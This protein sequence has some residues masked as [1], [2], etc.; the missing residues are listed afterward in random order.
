VV[1]SLHRKL[2]RD[3]LRLKGQA[4]TIALVLL[5]GVASWVSLR[6]TYDSL[7]DARVAY[8]ERQRFAD[9]FASCVRAPAAL[10]SRLAEIAGVKA[11]S[12]SVVEPIRIMIPSR[13]IPPT[14]VLAS[15][16][17]DPA[18]DAPRLMQGRFPLPD[19]ASEVVLLDSFAKSHDLQLGSHVTIVVAGVARE[20]TV[21]GWAVSPDYLFPVAPGAISA[22]PE[23][24]GVVW[25][26]VDA[27]RRL[28]GYEAAFNHVSLRLDKGADQ[29]E[30]I[31]AL[32]ALLAPWGGTGAHGRELHSS[33]R[34]MSQEL[35]QLKGMALVAPA[36]FLGVAAFLLHV[37]LGRLISLERTEIATLRSLGYSGADV[38]R[39]YA[40]LVLGIGAVGAAGGFLLGP[41]SVARWWIC[42]RGT[43]TFRIH[44]SSCISTWQPSACSSVSVLRFPVRSARWSPSED[45]RPRKRC[46]P[47]HRRPFARDCSIACALLACFLL[48]S[49][50]CCVKRAGD[51]CGLRL[52]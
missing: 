24:F 17:E 34:I 38:M 46:G 14:G 9:V 49:A 27:A 7:D 16:V 44:R 48:R 32:D 50:W 12:V 33:D 4:F 2:Y 37:V 11:L 23:R 18:T 26:S 15:V 29:A 3:V 25:M 21:V 40:E 20:L 22:D 19:A 5:C 45:C 39:H 47:R 35:T 28:T 13:A 8:Y 31:A 52:R 30:V 1:T 42:T 51:R 6:A 36:I 10:E 41:G 43:S